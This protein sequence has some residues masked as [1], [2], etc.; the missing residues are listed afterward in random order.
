MRAVLC[1]EFI[2]EN[3]FAYE[4]Q[5]SRPH[6]A[7]ERY[8]AFLGRDRSRP[9]VAQLTGITGSG[10][11]IRVFQRPQKDYCQANSTGSRGIY[12]Y[13]SLLP[14]YY[15]INQ[16]TS[17]THVRRWF[18]HVTGIDIEEITREEVYQCLSRD[19]ESPS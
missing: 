12:L 19:S 9:W 15:E 14:G 17:W 6:A 18:G 5:A 8:G 10:H 13:Y 4:Q 11:I 7:T 3:Y 2:G 1:L 16:R